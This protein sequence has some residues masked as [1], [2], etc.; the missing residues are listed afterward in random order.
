VRVLDRTVLPCTLSSSA[1]MRQ[2]GKTIHPHRGQRGVLRAVATFEFFKGIFVVIMG[3]CALALVQN[4]TSVIAQK[5]L[6]LLHISSDRHSAQVFLDFADSVTDARLW[7]AAR[8][9]FAYAALRFTEAYGL[10]HEGTWAEWVAF[11]SGTLLLPW[12]VRELFRGL[13]FWRCALLIGNLAVVCFML[14]II[15]ANRRERRAA[16]AAATTE[17]RASKGN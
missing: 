3:I 17:T 2:N 6:A 16:A 7:A 10:W 14:Y 8:I 11:L 13:A 5:M 1:F 4:D 12:E 9:A 15:I